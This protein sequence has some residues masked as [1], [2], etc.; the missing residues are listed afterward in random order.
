M[1][2][3]IML[4]EQLKKYREKSHLSQTEVAE[5]LAL[6]RQAISR[7]E[8]NRAY[9]DIDNL[10]RL[11]KLYSVT[12]DDLLAENET[13][14]KKL[15]INTKNIIEATKRQTFLN[16]KM[17]NAQDES[18]ELLILAIVSA[19]IPMLGI[20]IPIYVMFRNNKF[21]SLFRWIYIVAIIVLLVSL[22]ST[23]VWTYDMFFTHYHTETTLVN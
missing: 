3:N 12:L 10:I 5:N 4:G 19:I 15:N 16:R 17:Y 23:G 13:L 9:P 14:K 7:W 18:M 8:N 2:G 6:T 21:N 1:G 20:F 22:I 11:S